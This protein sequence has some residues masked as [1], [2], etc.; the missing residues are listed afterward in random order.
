MK[1]TPQQLQQYRDQ[2]F[3]VVHLFDEAHRKYYDL[4]LI[5]GEG[6]HVRWQR[7]AKKKTAATEDDAQE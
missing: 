1:L 3:L 5:W 2:G 4:E 7:R 6:P